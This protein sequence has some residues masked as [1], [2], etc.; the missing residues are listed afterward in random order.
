MTLYING[1]ENIRNLSDYNASK[2][3]KGRYDVYEY[4]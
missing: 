2:F 3:I 4:N 1:V